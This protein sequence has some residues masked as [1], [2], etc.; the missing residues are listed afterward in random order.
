MARFW[1]KYRTACNLL[2]KHKKAK[3]AGWVG[4][5]RSVRRK[6]SQRYTLIR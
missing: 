6:K 5:A 2:K 4:N 1:E 3:R